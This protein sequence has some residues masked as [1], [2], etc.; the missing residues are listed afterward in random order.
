MEVEDE[1][2]P[3]RIRL[4]DEDPN[5]NDTLHS[6][7]GSDFKRRGSPE[8]WEH[9]LSRLNKG[10]SGRITCDIDERGT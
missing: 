6:N 9:F 2:V 7:R 10:V 3:V 5:S 8:A 4:G 1:L